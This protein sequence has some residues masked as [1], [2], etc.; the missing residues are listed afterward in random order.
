MT[1]IALTSLPRRIAEMTGANPKNYRD[2]YNKTLSGLWPA[3]Q[4]NGRWHIDES[5]LPAV[6]QALG[7]PM[8]DATRRKTTRPRKAA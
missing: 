4:I 3:T 2:L 5:D 1:T 8:A 6:I 7:L